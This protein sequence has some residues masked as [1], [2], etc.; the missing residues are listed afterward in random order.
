M[1]FVIGLLGSGIGAGLMVIIQML[2]KRKWAKEDQH[3]EKTEKLNDLSTRLIDIDTKL[4]GLANDVSHVKSANKSILSDRIKWLG[5]K[6]LEAGEIEFEDRR[7][8][9]N[10]HDAY[11]DDCGGNGDFKILMKNVDSLPLK[12][13]E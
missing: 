10:L 8:L 4:D 12:V 2:L 9:H 13:R 11:H 6:Y 3:D 5:T 1:E 7:I